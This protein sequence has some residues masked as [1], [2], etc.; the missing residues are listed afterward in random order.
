MCEVCEAQLENYKQ[1]LKNKNNLFDVSNHRVSFRNTN[2][3]E[4]EEAPLNGKSGSHDSEDET[5]AVSASLT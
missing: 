2:D 1:S 3:F 5:P 4:E